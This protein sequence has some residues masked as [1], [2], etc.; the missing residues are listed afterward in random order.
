MVGEE[1]FLEIEVYCWATEELI[2][3]KVVQKL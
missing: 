1:Y 2:M 3:K